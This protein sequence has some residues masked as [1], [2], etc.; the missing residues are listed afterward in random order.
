MSYDLSIVTT[1]MNRL[2]PQFIPAWQNVV[3]ECS[4]NKRPVTSIPTRAGQ[5]KFTYT[6]YNTLSD[7]LLYEDTLRDNISILLDTFNGHFVSDH[8]IRFDTV[9]DATEFVLRY[10]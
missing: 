2:Y 8:V 3:A 9:E 10:S 4:S 5:F 6:H 7:A 1:D